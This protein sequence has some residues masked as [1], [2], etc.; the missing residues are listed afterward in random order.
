VVYLKS[1]G[2]YSYPSLGTFKEAL[3]MADLILNSHGGIISNQDAAE[4]LNYT[5][6]DP[7]KISGSF[8]G[9][10]KDLAA[11]GLFEKVR[12]GYKIT[13]LAEKALDPYEVERA[14]KGKREAIR[15]IRVVELAYTRL[16]GKIPSENAF[17]A[18]IAQITDV[19]WI[20]ARKHDESLRNLFIETFPYL[21]ATSE[22]TTK[23]N[24]QIK[25]E[26]G[27]ET[28]YM[29]SKTTIGRM[30]V[31]ARGTGF[32]FTKT[33]PFTKEG[34]QKLRKLVNFLEAQI[35]EEKTKGIPKSVSEQD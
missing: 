34:I 10:M 33:L 12:G 22:P 5:V 14:D 3:E 16:G 27:G 32:G 29:D 18:K 13:S 4:H 15:K 26:A 11:F 31:S 19:S 20:E 8:Y 24:N 17:P 28:I 2:H 25:A 7:S 6:K 1:I 30:T 35:E 9:K 21:E 23:I